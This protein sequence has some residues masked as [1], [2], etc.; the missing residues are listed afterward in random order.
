[1]THIPLDIIKRLEILTNMCNCGDCSNSYQKTSN[2]VWHNTSSS[3]MNEL[4]DGDGRFIALARPKGWN[5]F[6]YI[7]P[8]CIF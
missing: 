5:L 7:M 2:L 6:S 3:G 8:D 4:L 1:M